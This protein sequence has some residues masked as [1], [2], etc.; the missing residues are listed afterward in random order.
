MRKFIPILFS[1]PMVQAILEDR[2]TGTRRVVKPQPP[3]EDKLD[4]GEFNPSLTNKDGDEY[5]GPDTFG[6]I[7]DGEFCIKCP[8]GKPGDVLWVRES[9]AYVLLGVKY[10]SDGDWTREEKEFG[11]TL[12]WKPST[13]MPKTACR[14]FLEVLSIKVERLQDISEEDAIAE[15]IEPLKIYSFPIYRNYTPESGCKDGYQTPRFSF[16]SLWRS[17]NGPESWNANPW[18]WVIQFKKIERPADFLPTH[19][20]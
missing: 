4:V 12:P 14:I 13:H 19:N 8:Y 9:F 15:G 7:S 2:K 6:A 16:Q 1:T 11:M 20:S 17:I 10:K 3:E 18:V 5:P